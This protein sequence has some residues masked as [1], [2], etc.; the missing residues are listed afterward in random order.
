VDFSKLQI[1]SLVNWTDIFGVDNQ[2]NPIDRN[3]GINLYQT[4]ILKSGLADGKTYFFRVRYRDHNLKWSDW[5]LPVSFSKVGTTNS[6]GLKNDQSEDNSLG[7]NYPNPFQQR[8]TIEYRIAEMTNVLFRIYDKNGRLIQELNE[9]TKPKGNYHL[10]C[11][12]NMLNA[13]I[14]FYQMITNQSVETKRMTKME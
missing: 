3:R 2:F 14:Y 12:S 13:G 4:T 9:G 1:N 7:Q 10:T 11:R 6:F 5:S 8:T